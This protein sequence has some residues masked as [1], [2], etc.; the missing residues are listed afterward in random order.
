MDDTINKLTYHLYLSMSFLWIRFR[1]WLCSC[2][3]T[4]L[5]TQSSAWLLLLCCLRLGLRWVSLL[6]LP[7]RCRKRQICKWPAL[8]TLTW[9]P[10]PGAPLLTLLQCKDK[11]LHEYLW[12]T[13]HS[14][15]TTVLYLTLLN[16]L[17]YISHFSA[18]ASNVAVKILSPKFDRLSYTFS[19]AFH[20][21]F[22]SCEGLFWQLV[23][24]L[25]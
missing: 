14:L 6:P 15:L 12:T 13:W 7:M 20:L 9:N 24:C 5:S 2:S 8:C 4:G 21:D 22:Y 10:W 19:K 11:F 25:S 1:K 3:W 16:Y 18:A 23:F 17:I